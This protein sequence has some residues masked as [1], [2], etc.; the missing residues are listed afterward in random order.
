MEITALGP[1]D[2]F[3]VGYMGTSDSVTKGRR[4]W[5]N[6]SVCSFRTHIFLVVVRQRK[7][8]LYQHKLSLQ[9]L[10]FLF[11]F[12]PQHPFIETWIQFKTLLQSHNQANFRI[13]TDA[14]MCHSHQPNNFLSLLKCSYLI[15]VLP[16]ILK[17][18]LSAGVLHLCM[19]NQHM[20]KP[21][22]WCMEEVDTWFPP[23]IPS[24]RT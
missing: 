16:L 1:L 2:S 18:S 17:T 9:K 24:F 7:F 12:F 4:N 23:W 5:C 22:L 3:M 20:R 13:G 6:H 10:H 14:V 19:R 11:P 15:F 21:H 8:S